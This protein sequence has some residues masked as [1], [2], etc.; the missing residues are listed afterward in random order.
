VKSEVV[1]RSVPDNEILAFDSRG[2]DLVTIEDAVVA[3]LNSTLDGVRAVSSMDFITNTDTV[4]PLIVCTAGEFQPDMARFGRDTTNYGPGVYPGSTGKN[5][6]VYGCVVSGPLAVRCMAR[7]S[8]EC[9]KV[10]TSVFTNLL[11]LS[12]F[13]GELLGVNSFVVQSLEATK[14]LSEETSGEHLWV[15]GIQCRLEAALH[16]SIERLAP[17]LKTL[18]GRLS[19]DALA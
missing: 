2:F 1:S 4:F 11:A 5:D 12:P 3:L 17:R 10:A 13:V 18:G 14:K 7:T 8:R 19:I 9:R 15:S 6:M 16:W